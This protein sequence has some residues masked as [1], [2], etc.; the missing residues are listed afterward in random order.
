MFGCGTHYVIFSARKFT[1]LIAFCEF[2]SESAFP[3]L[4]V[5]RRR[6]LWE[7]RGHVW[8]LRLLGAGLRL[9][10]RVGPALPTPACPPHV[11]GTVLNILFHL[12]NEAHG[13]L[14][15]LICL[16]EYA[17]N[18]YEV[19]TVLQGAHDGGAE[20]TARTLGKGDPRLLSKMGGQ[21]AWVLV[22]LLLRPPCR[23]P[24]ALSSQGPGRE[25][26]LR[27]TE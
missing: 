13:P 18:R 12:L 17:G 15:M 24:I 27:P 8:D 5:T 26:P 3:G 2:S 1:F 19:A 9:H 14:I 25:L 20:A 23:C 10:P 21:D 6:A 22:V 7:G 11:L 16:N 4:T